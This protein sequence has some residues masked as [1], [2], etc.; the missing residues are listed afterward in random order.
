MVMSQSGHDEV[1]GSLSQLSSEISDTLLNTPELI[2]LILAHLDL[3]TLLHAQ[4]VS[5]SFRAL[6]LNSSGCQRALFF[7][8]EKTRRPYE[9]GMTCKNELLEKKFGPWFKDAEIT[10]GSLSRLELAHKRDAYMRPEASWR[11]MLVAQPPIAT[12]RTY[13]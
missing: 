9:N 12:L 5:R 11:K 7:V 4:R 13:S 3:A 1:Q 2:C 10:E 8:G 6:I